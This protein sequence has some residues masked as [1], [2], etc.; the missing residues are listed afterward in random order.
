MNITWHSA[1]PERFRLTVFKE[2]QS[3]Q[4]PI[5]PGPWVGAWLWIYSPHTREDEAGWV[6]AAHGFRRN[7]KVELRSPVGLLATIEDASDF[8]EVEDVAPFAAAARTEPL[9]RVEGLGSI[10]FIGDF[11]AAPVPGGLLPRSSYAQMALDNA[12]LYTEQERRELYARG[13]ESQPSDEPLNQFVAAAIVP[14]RTLKYRSDRPYRTGRSTVPDVIDQWDTPSQAPFPLYECAAD[15]E[16]F[17]QIAFQTAVKLGP[18][19]GYE[20]C[21]AVVVL[22]DGTQNV[23]HAMAMCVDRTWLNAHWDNPDNMDAAKLPHVPLDG[24]E[25]SR[26]IPAPGELP[27]HVHY[28]FLVALLRA[29]GLR[30]LMHKDA[31]AGVP[32]EN[33]SVRFVSHCDK[34]E[35]QRRRWTGAELVRKYMPAAHAEARVGAGT[36]GRYDNSATSV[37]G[38][39]A[40][41]HLRDFHLNAYTT[42]DAFIRDRRGDFPTR[43]G[44]YDAHFALEAVWGRPVPSDI[45]GFDYLRDT[46][47]SAITTD[48]NEYTMGIFIKGGKAIVVI[49]VH[50]WRRGTEAERDAEAQIEVPT[51]APD[52]RLF[53]DSSFLVVTGIV[54]PF[55]ISTTAFKRVTDLLIEDKCEVLNLREPVD[56]L[57]LKQWEEKAREWT[58]LAYESSLAFNNADPRIAYLRVKDSV[59]ISSM[60]PSALRNTAA[61][62]T[63]TFVNRL[64]LPQNGIRDDPML[65]IEVAPTP[66]VDT[67][68]N[69]N[70]RLVVLSTSAFI[71]PPGDDVNR[72]VVTKATEDE[73]NPVFFERCLMRIIGS[74]AGFGNSVALNGVPL[75]IDRQ[76]EELSS[77]EGKLKSYALL[78]PKDMILV[79]SY[80]AIVTDVSAAMER[81][82]LTRD[83]K[84][85]DV[86]IVFHVPISNQL[87]EFSGVQDTQV[88]WPIPWRPPAGK[89]RMLILV[90]VRDHTNSVNVN[91]IPFMARQRAQL[92]GKGFELTGVWVRCIDVSNREARDSAYVAGVVTGLLPR[93]RDGPDKVVVAQEEKTPAPAASAPVKRSAPARNVIRVAI[94]VDEHSSVLTRARPY[95]EHKEDVVTEVFNV[96][97]EDTSDLP[98][99]RRKRVAKADGVLVFHAA[100][101]EARVEFEHLIAPECNRLRADGA[102]NLIV[103]VCRRNEGD[104]L[105]SPINVRS[106]TKELLKGIPIFFIDYNL[107]RP[108]NEVYLHP[109]NG[110]RYK[111]IADAIQTWRGARRAVVDASPA[112]EVV[113]RPPVRVEPPVVQRTPSPVRAAAPVVDQPVVAPGPV[114]PT[115]GTVVRY[116]IV[117]DEVSDTL[118]LGFAT[119]IA[120][121]LKPS[122]GDVRLQYSP[123]KA[124]GVLYFHR[125]VDDDRIMDQIIVAKCRELLGTGVRNVA[126]ILCVRNT[127]STLTK[128]VAADRYEGLFGNRVRVFRVDVQGNAPNFL[129]HPGNGPRYEAIAEAVRHWTDVDV[130]VGASAAAQP[131]VPVQ[132]ARQLAPVQAAVP[133]AIRP[134]TG[135]AVVYAIVNDPTGDM[136]KRGIVRRIT[137]EQGIPTRESREVQ[138]DFLIVFAEKKVSS[139]D[140][141]RYELSRAMGEWN[142]RHIMLVAVHDSDEKESGDFPDDILEATDFTGDLQLKDRAIRDQ[143]SFDTLLDRMAGWITLTFRDAASADDAFAETVL[144]PRPDDGRPV[145]RT[146]TPSPEP[147]NG[148]PYSP[149]PSDPDNGPLA[150]YGD[151][152]SEAEFKQWYDENVLLI[153]TPVPPARPRAASL[154]SLRAPLGP[155]VIPVPAAPAALAPIAEYDPFDDAY[156]GGHA[157]HMHYS[158]LGRALAARLST[159]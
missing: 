83:E 22:S 97:P 50:H 10:P 93:V 128:D 113:Q 107:V 66:A 104:L 95:V 123:S 88:R 34:E 147:D 157:A 48:P 32:W 86:A 67:V 64:K 62:A 101:A 7:G 27:T 115:G 112:A 26:A 136:T 36:A 159:E 45:G 111:Q 98:I 40:D 58:E 52:T 38:K 99:V 110:P 55:F 19:E 78:S 120:P 144:M 96:L 1:A 145:V 150:T 81:T 43:R 49:V 2:G 127:V 105:H 109:A 65:Q 6:R 151:T 122:L 158:A 91:M 152:D 132:P 60:L 33:T 134:P 53:R 16:E 12:A 20:A 106:E 35:Q 146:A 129:W 138:T 156:D 59:S 80:S 28:P 148:R 119:T 87:P 72:I 47:R 139:W 29:D 44:V 131:D 9:E 30:I 114:Q 42:A 70:A 18:P 130:P 54:Q 126:V 71:V 142:W 31:V 121:K 46:L 117:T 15:C 149:S 37:V 103:I 73:F 13:M 8:M 137:G 76:P 84:N 63:E 108:G 21:L 125:V 82:G 68:S 5:G 56:E 140:E 135:G 11:F 94:H 89:Y 17:A 75:G 69:Q 77:P 79:P 155:L 143:G 57:S 116:R 14:S 51:F 118:T 124:D 23:M 3:L 153:S 61:V 74:V 141:V 41:A 4:D 24:V 85:P 25:H 100:A 133:V 90:V 154:G 39:G 102:K 92:A